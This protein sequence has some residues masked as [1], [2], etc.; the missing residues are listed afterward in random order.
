MTDTQDPEQ[1]GSEVEAS[2]D[3]VSPDAKSGKGAARAKQAASAPTSGSLDVAILKDRIKIFPNKPLKD[4]ANKEIM[5]YQASVSKGE[6]ELIAYVCKPELLPRTRAA[7]KYGAIVNPNT[8]K[9]FDKGVVYWPPDKAQRYVIVYER[10][11]QKRLYDGSKALALGMKPDV[12]MNSFIDPMIHLLQDFRNKDFV[13]GGISA[14]NVFEAGALNGQTKYVIGD[15]LTIPPFYLLPRLYKS[16]HV[17]MADPIAGGIGTP[18]DDMYAFGITIAAMIRHKDPVAGLSEQDVIRHKIEHGSYNTM[19]AGERLKGNFADLLRGLLNDDPQHRWTVEEAL[20]WLDGKRLNQ[21]QAMK[22]PRGNR[23]IEFSDEQYIYPS[24]LAMDMRDNKEETLKIVE[25][26][27]I[28]Q[29][30]DR[31]FDGREMLESVELAI[32][33]AAE[34]KSD[35]KFDDRLIC[36]MSSA[37]DPLAPLRY[38]DKTIFADSMGY[39]LVKAVVAKED[40]NA[41]IEMINDYLVNNWILASEHHG[42]DKNFLIG[43]FE[44]MRRTLLNPK[45]G[46]AFERIIYDLAPHVH[47]LSEKLSDYIV[48]TSADL[49]RAFD[50][51]CKK[52]KAP[53][54]FLDRH[55]IAFLMARDSKSIEPCLHDLNSVK[56]HIQLFANLKCFASIQM[57]EATGPLPDLAKHLNKVLDEVVERYHD[58]ERRETVRVELQKTSEKGDLNKML[59]LLTDEDIKKADMTGFREARVY[60]YNYYEE[61]NDL[62][63]KFQSPHLFGQKLG[64]EI[65]AVVATIIALIV[66]TGIFYLGYMGQTLY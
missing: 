50:D 30:L 29:W 45:V 8:L 58:R 18:A 57:R 27:L 4:L 65:A 10:V 26:Q 64:N 23:P 51:L 54:I 46:H 25:G 7:S 34:K 62:E 24:L 33:R 59:Q 36:M 15:T 20:V 1:E 56:K 12:V 11:I 13:H 63:K 66:F 49:I 16:I 48:Y 6:R 47:C 55:S 60:F 3:E 42:L 43:R 37:L 14:C 31:A 40:Y 17:A 2:K 44:N 21:K 41:Y 52:G 9:I 39:A 5:A 28:H 38:K 32:Q 19:I 35:K 53:G 61:Q 22:L